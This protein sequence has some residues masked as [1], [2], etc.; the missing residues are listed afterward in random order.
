[1]KE[2]KL[3]FKVKKKLKFLQNSSNKTKNRIMKM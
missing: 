2:N 3:K 1:M